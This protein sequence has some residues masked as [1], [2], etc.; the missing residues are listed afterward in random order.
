MKLTIVKYYREK[1][2]LITGDENGIIIIWNLKTGKSIFY[3]NAHEG[4][5]T[6]MIFLPQIKIIITSGKDKYF[7]T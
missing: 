4:P 5:I 6:Q 2:Q 1:N 3:W 7:K